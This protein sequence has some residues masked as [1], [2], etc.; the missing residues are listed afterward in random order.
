MNHCTINELANGMVEDVKRAVHNLME[1]E[2]FP[3]HI[4]PSYGDI[5]PQ[6]LPAVTWLD[7]SAIDSEAVLRL[8]NACEGTAKMLLRGA[9]TGE[10]YFIYYPAG[11]RM[12]PHKDPV[13]KGEYWRMGVVITGADKGGVLSINGK[14]ITLKVG[15]G[16]LFEA[17]GSEHEVSEVEEGE[18]IVFTMAFYVGEDPHMKRSE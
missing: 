11:T 15:D 16:Y 5:R 12:H 18:R 7:K 9:R 17:A 10:S 1:Q 6:R 14:Q 2:P 13:P 4:H 8:A 3:A